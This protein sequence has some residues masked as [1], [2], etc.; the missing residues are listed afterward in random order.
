MQSDVY[1]IYIEIRYMKTIAQNW[2][3]IVCY[4]KN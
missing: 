4:K 1:N 2:G 3:Y